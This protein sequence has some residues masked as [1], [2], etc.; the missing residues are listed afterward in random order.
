MLFKRHSSHAVLLMIMLF[1]VFTVTAFGSPWKTEEIQKPD[2]ALS[3]YE[4]GYQNYR[5][6]LFSAAE[7]CFI[8][9]L[10]QEPNL[11]KAHYWLG[12][13]YREQGRLEDAIFH[14]EEVERLNQLIK[15]RRIALSL[16]NN[17]YPSYPQMLK[18]TER[19]K[20]AHEAYLKGIHLLDEG[21]WD[22]AEVEIR[23]AVAL[24][25]GNH[26]YLIRLARLL[27]DKGEQQASVK[28]YRDLLSMRDVNIVDFIEGFDRMLAARMDY[29][30]QPLLRLHE[31]RFTGHSEYARMRDMFKAVSK[32]EVVAAGKIVKKLNGQVIINLGMQEGLS[33][34]DEFSLSLRSFKAGGTLSDPDTGVVI[35]RAPDIPSAELL[36]TKV[37]KNTSWALIRKEFGP[38]VKA[39]DLIEFKKAAR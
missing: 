15:D 32:H 12:K 24:Y 20:L 11:I 27:W 21:H 28:F 23:K 25:G 33:L 5:K 6:G 10:R 34:S 14:W 29:V 7:D 37:Y 8:E 13:L 18:T 2:R 26:E 19:A 31:Q 3:A 22:G 39:G 36:L 17:E 38:G 35:G 1:T 30:A 9:A 16:Q 4:K